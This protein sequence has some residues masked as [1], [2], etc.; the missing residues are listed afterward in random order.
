[1]KLP[2]TKKYNWRIMARNYGPHLFITTVVI[3]CLLILLAVNLYF[4][5]YAARLAAET[6]A[7]TIHHTKHIPPMGA[8]GTTH[9][10]MVEGTWFMQELRKAR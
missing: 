2:L 8:P 7:N 3:A 10:D 4:Q 6:Y 9:T 1:M 5:E